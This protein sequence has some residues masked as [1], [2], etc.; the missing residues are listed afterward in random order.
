MKILRIPRKEFIFTIDQ[1]LVELASRKNVY[2]EQNA[3]A[4]DDPVL[5]PKYGEIHIYDMRKYCKEMENEP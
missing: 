4:F 5:N 1:L 2:Y 3:S